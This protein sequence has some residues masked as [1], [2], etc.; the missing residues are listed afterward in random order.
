MVRQKIVDASQ[1]C[2][3]RFMLEGKGWS[4]WRMISAHTFNEMSADMVGRFH[5]GTLYW[6][7]KP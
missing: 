2:W 1:I 3:T 6:M 4:Q 5:A 7:R